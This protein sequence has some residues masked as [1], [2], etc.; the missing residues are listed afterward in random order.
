MKG[1]KSLDDA[2]LD[3]RFAMGDCSLGAIL[4]AA[5]NRG[6]CAIMLGDRSDTLARDAET[7]FPGARLAGEDAAFDRIVSKVIAFVEAQTARP[8]FPID[9]Q[10]TP[11]QRRV[12]QAL[13]EIPPGS[14][15]SYTDIANRI[16]SPK[17]VRAVGRACG[18]N[19][20]AVLIPCHR[21]VRSDGCLAGYRWGLERKRVLLD[22]EA[23][24]NYALQLDLRVAGA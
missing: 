6:V 22:R 12:W 15:A 5:S 11:F 10:G 3:I 17:A 2:H 19:P 20:L 1:R 16:G 18:A 7:R 9:V 8:E 13:R 24:G 23:F 14:T 4:V 21:A